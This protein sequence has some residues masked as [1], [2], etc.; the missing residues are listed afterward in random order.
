MDKFDASRTLLPA[1]TTWVVIEGGNHAQFGDY[2]IQPGD[3]VAT[4]SAAEQQTQI[5]D[6]TVIF[7]LLGQ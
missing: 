5:V 4:I 6:A 1:D 2:G 7:D 3:N